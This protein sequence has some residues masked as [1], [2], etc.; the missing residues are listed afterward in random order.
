MSGTEMP[1]SVDHF[2]EGVTIGCSPPIALDDISW[3]VDSKP[4]NAANLSREVQ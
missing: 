2:Q 4:E 3:L 1:D